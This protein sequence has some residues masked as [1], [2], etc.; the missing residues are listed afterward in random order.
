MRGFSIVILICQNLFGTVHLLWQPI[1]VF[2]RSPLPPPFDRNHQH[3]H[4]P[5]LSL[6]ACLRT[7][8]TPFPLQSNLFPK[9][10]LGDTI[11]LMT[12]CVWVCKRERM[13]LW[14]NLTFW[15]FTLDMK[16]WL[17]IQMPGVAWAIYNK[18]LRNFLKPSTTWEFHEWPVGLSS[19]TWSLCWTIMVAWAQFILGWMVCGQWY[20]PKYFLWSQCIAMSV[21]I[22]L[23]MALTMTW[24]WP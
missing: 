24:P 9:Y 10:Q 22:I 20:I 1:R 19:T 6:W 12:K 5:L 7:W 11:S 16:S 21:T 13:K 8:V 14:T 17:L 2:Y 23:A 4:G 15:V 18:S 3:F